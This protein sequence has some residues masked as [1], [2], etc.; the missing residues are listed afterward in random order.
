MKRKDFADDIEIQMKKAITRFVSIVVGILLIAMVVALL[1]SQLP[2]PSHEV[3]PTEAALEYVRQFLPSKSG[4]PQILLTRSIRFKDYPEL[5][6]GRF[7]PAAGSDPQLELVLFKGDFD[8]SNYGFTQ[9]VPFKQASYVVIVYDLEQKAIT[10]VTVSVN[11][12]ELKNLLIMA[13][14]KPANQ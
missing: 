1:L 6:L 14:E 5:G 9:K 8:T 11:G 13:G 2:T 4:R 7:T 3:T 12:A 10:N